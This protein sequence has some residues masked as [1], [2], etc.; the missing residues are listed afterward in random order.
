MKARP[1]LFNAEMV[2]ALLDG[3]KTQTRRAVKGVMGNNH[4]FLRKPTK[5]KCGITTHVLGAPCKGL[6]PFGQVG[7]L[8][9]VRES[10][11][12][13]VRRYAGGAG[14]FLVFRASRPDAVY[15]TTCNGGS[16]AMKWKP[17]IHMPRR[18]SRLTLKITDVRVERVQDINEDDSQNEGVFYTDYGLDKY[19]TLRNGWSFKS[20]S[21]HIQ[22]LGSA[23]FA[24]ANL[25]ISTGGNW[26]DNPWVWVIDFEVIHKNVDKVLE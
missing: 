8:L 25:W 2:R 23:R 1:I 3:R 4:L 26:D 7:D 20:T 17:S 9:Y 14:E 22:C 11:G 6:C 15:C 24:F 10:F 16:I 18:L 12:Y 21:S 5:K 19:R 13:E